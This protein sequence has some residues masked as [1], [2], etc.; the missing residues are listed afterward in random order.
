M[1]ASLI[2]CAQPDH[3]HAQMT[4]MA[5][6]IESNPNTASRN[7][8]DPR[9]YL[10]EIEGT[11]AMAWVR[12][13]N[14]TTLDRLSKDPRFARFQADALKILEAT[15]RIATPGF[16]HNGM[17][18]NLWQDGEH[19]QG[20]WRQTTWASYASGKPNWDVILDIDALSKA[21]GKNWVWEGADCLAP[22]YTRCLISLSDGGKDANVVREF[23][24]ATSAS[25]RTASSCR[26]ASRV[27]PGVMPTPSMS[28][29]SGLRVT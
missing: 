17:V 16:A 20:I 3:L 29:A 28:P 18:Q 2:V 14:Q 13:H 1:V 21:E 11:R 4:T 26:K 8:A 5:K 19:V 24:I 6:A 23:D 10:D 22:E 9:A 7:A 27:L 15:D 12:A 25:S